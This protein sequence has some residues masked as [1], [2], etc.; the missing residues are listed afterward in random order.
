MKF[1][2]LP[3]L[4]LFS[5]LFVFIAESAR[6]IKAPAV[7][8][9]FIA[10]HFAYSNFSESET[11]PEED[12]DRDGLSNHDEFLFGTDPTQSDRENTHLRFALDQG[13][14]TVTGYGR[15]GRKYTLQTTEN[16][17]TAWSDVSQFSGADREESHGE[18]K[19]SAT[20]KFFR[21]KVDVIPPLYVNGNSASQNPD[22]LS[23]DTAFP[24]L[25]EAID[26]AET[27][28][29]IWVAEGVYHPT[30]IDP[31]SAAEDSA[32]PRARTFFLKEGIAIVGGFA[33]TENSIS[34]RPGNLK[35]VL[36]GDFNQDDVW[37]ENGMLTEEEK[38]KFFENAYHVVAAFDLQIPVL[39]MS[40]EI[41]GGFAMEFAEVEG[42]RIV[43]DGAGGNY[44]AGLV[45]V[46]SN[47]QIAE[48]RF[49]RNIAAHGGGAIYASGLTTPVGSQTIGGNFASINLLDGFG[50]TEFEQNHVAENS[51]TGL[52][53]GSGGAVSI[54]DNTLADF[55]GA[56]FIDNSAPVGGAV[57]IGG[58]AHLD[59][60][61]NQVDLAL[62]QPTA[63][64]VNCGF[65]G[66]KALTESDS[67]SNLVS[68]YGGA[69][70]A[71]YFANLEVASCYFG[72][73]QSLTNNYFGSDGDEGGW[74]G[75]IGIYAGATARIALTVFDNN[76]ADA[77]GGAIDIG[78]YVSGSTASLDINLS[79]FYGNTSAGAPAI[80]NEDAVVVG[81]GNIFH[82]NIDA[83][84]AA[85]DLVNYGS[86]ST[87][88]I[89]QSLFSGNNTA[90]GNVGTDN[91]SIDPSVA[92]FT[93]P[94]IPEGVDGEWNTDDD[95]FAIAFELR[96]ID[97]R[98]VTRPLPN[99]FADFDTDGDHDEELPTDS[100]GNSF[101]EGPFFYGA[102]PELE[103]PN[104]N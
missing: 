102:Y 79:T 80:G 53:A 69:I 68:G 66:N 15:M 18:A 4:I 71:F 103:I 7:Y 37:T 88:D 5:F 74:G 43:V 58:Y 27:G 97:R 82:A 87:F 30:E 62:E 92:L 59:A 34:E 2:S 65:W 32:D 72:F 44:G 52:F 36:S 94:Q 77:G 17:V 41:T 47:I 42:N 28:Q 67:D 13:S 100:F 21:V 9:D 31:F 61:L 38:E 101:G 81:K 50:N 6:A 11:G 10:L 14:L 51:E 26:A 20:K 89:S 57:S 56:I 22:G 78:E 35:T 96:T 54:L 24:N 63:V 46:S 70:C 1:L 40:L 85:I 45:M 91:Q 48:C 95:G 16:L 93:N 98:I 25:Q 8:E 73:N 55:R 76:F 29:E 83:D 99:D 75:A 64:F 12:P 3:V 49:F 19:G 23:W 86:N 33:G 39:L 90:A 60:Y 84:D 104:E